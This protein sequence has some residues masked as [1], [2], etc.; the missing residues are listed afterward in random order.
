M[1][2]DCFEISINVVVKHV[3][4]AGIIWAF[5]LPGVDLLSFSVPGRTEKTTGLWFARGVSTRAD[6]MPN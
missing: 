4:H 6:T 2:V 3:Q 5:S 1:F